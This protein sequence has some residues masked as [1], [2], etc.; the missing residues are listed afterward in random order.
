MPEDWTHC[1]GIDYNPA[2]D[3]IVLSSREF[4]EFWIIDHSTTTAQA[5]GHTGGRSGHGGDLLYRYGNPQTYDRGTAADRVFY[6]QHDP[7]WI[8]AGSPGAGDITVF[9]NGVGRPNDQDYSSVYEITPPTPDA[10]GNYPLSAGQAYGP[11]SATWVY[12][13]PQADYS[14]IIGSATRL[15]NGNTLIDYGV[16]ATFSEV[17]P[18]GQEVWRYVSPYT[19]GGTLGPTTPIPSLGLPPPIL[20]S[21]YANFTFQAIYYGVGYVAPRIDLNGAAAETDFTATSSGGAAVLA[22]DPTATMTDIDSANF[23]S[24][25]VAIAGTHVG[26]TLTANT[27]GTSITASYANGTLSL[28]GSDTIAH[29]QT[30]LRTIKYQNT[31][32][33]PGADMVTLNFTANDGTQNS[34]TAVATIDLPP[35]LDLD[36][37]ASGTSFITGWYNSGTNAGGAVPISNM[38]NALVK[39]NSGLANLTGLTVTL[40]TFHAGDVL[41]LANLPVALG[42]NISASYSSGTLSLTG[43]DTFAHYQEALRFISY[44]NTTGMGPG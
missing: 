2:L 43:S 1:N 11:T 6:Y 20:S 42:L 16:D 37:V 17:T 31:A 27:S 32:G 30:V 8:P 26:D 29:Y 10:S 15:P 7:K 44:N 33:G 23:A 40:A 4:S 35:S 38:T 14:A 22:T 9:N 13:A 12:V 18:A 24:L 25:T 5:A 41:A 21:L 34:N 36:G 19:G 28:S 3:Q 39:S